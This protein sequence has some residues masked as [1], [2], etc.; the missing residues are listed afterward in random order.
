MATA[1]FAQVEQTHSYDPVSPDVAA[2]RAV[3][4][5]YNLTNSK[6]ELIG[7]RTDLVYEPDVQAA[8]ERA[9]VVLRPK[10]YLVRIFGRALFRAQSVYQNGF[11]SESLR[12]IASAGMVYENG[13]Y[14]HEGIVGRARVSIETGEP[15]AVMSFRTPLPN[16]RS[17]ALDEEESRAIAEANAGES[18][19]AA[20]LVEFLEYQFAW[21]HPGARGDHYVDAYSGFHLSQEEMGSELQAMHELFAA[22]ADEEGVATSKYT[23]GPVFS[24]QGMQQ[25]QYTPDLPHLCGPT[26]LA[27]LFDYWGEEIDHVDVADVTT[28][29]GNGSFYNDLVRG[30]MFSE[31]SDGLF[32]HL[33]D[34]LV[35][36]G[37]DEREYGYCGSYGKFDDD[38]WGSLVE[39]VEERCPFIAIIRDTPPPEEMAH[40]VLVLGYQIDGSNDKWV[41]AAD[42]KDSDLFDGGEEEWRTWDA[43]G[44]DE[45][46]DSRWDNRFYYAIV[47][48]PLPVSLTLLP[49]TPWRGRF[50]LTATVR[51]C[52]E[53]PDAEDVGSAW[54]YVNGGTTLKRN[55][56]G[57]AG[58]P[59]TITFPGNV[60]KVS[61]SETQYF[62]PAGVDDEATISWDFTDDGNQLGGE[63]KVEMTGWALDHRSTSYTT[64]QDD[65]LLG[66]A[67]LRMDSKLFRITDS[68]GDTVAAIGDEGNLYLAGTLDEWDDAIAR[69]SNASEL[70]VKDGSTGDLAALFDDTGELSI[71]GLSHGQMDDFRDTCDTVDGNS[72]EQDYLNNPPAHSLKVKNSNGN[73]VAY[74]DEDGNLR[75]K[76][77]AQS[78]SRH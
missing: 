29:P 11:A 31:E 73:V 72:S 34:G 61:G 5:F 48:R 62:Y 75:L 53:W 19:E 55:T 60:T 59:V 57:T 30:A 12:A 8:M 40:A 77:C 14:Y 63:F 21:R 74:I 58:I 3:E 41:S 47:A 33:D 13:Q 23:L 54:T 46:F 15:I 70:V 52:H 10:N 20:E 50:R 27:M 56:G 76:G 68:S 35:Q 25:H 4:T 7:T 37:F 38:P 28:N 66:W 39:M 64:D 9:E 22:M 26:S 44:D 42:P 1:T 45:G 6:A 69:D 17:V 18:L 24:E 71:A 65:E 51:T 2:K 36:D 49:D 43:E 32:D 67:I 78:Q 16:L